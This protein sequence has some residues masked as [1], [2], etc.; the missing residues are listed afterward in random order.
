M[1]R[2]FFFP[3]Y[4]EKYSN[5]LG[6]HKN[7]IKRKKKQNQKINYFKPQTLTQNQIKLSQISRDTEQIQLPSPSLIPPYFQ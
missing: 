7:K 2:F 6:Q 4:I 3:F 5:I 1:L